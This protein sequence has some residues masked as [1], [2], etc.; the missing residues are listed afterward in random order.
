VQGSDLNQRMLLTKPGQNGGQKCAAP[1]TVSG[2][3]EPSPLALRGFLSLFSRQFSGHECSA[4]AKKK[5]PASFGKLDPSRVPREQLE[6]E[7]ILQLADLLA[8]CGLRD[9]K[10]IRGP[11]QA[12]LLGDS[13]KI[14]K[15]TQLHS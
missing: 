6:S 2:D 8:Q 13:N 1:F 15:V 4:P 5:N 7:L 11:S 9:M 12:R 3:H 14:A 10:P